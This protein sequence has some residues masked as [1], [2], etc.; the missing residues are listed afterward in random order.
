MR[1]VEIWTV[2][3]THTNL[4]SFS[5]K[6]FA[7][8]CWVGYKSLSKTWTCDLCLCFRD[9]NP[10]ALEQDCGTGCLHQEHQGGWRGSEVTSCS[11]TCQSGLSPSPTNTVTLWLGL[12]EFCI[13]WWFILTCVQGECSLTIEGTMLT[14]D[15]FPVLLW[16]KNLSMC[17]DPRG[18]TRDYFFSLCHEKRYSSLGTEASFPWLCL[19]DF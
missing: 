17:V 6:G 18:H 2:L 7:Q 11:Y 8:P 19:T 4:L 13:S 5:L 3:A 15:F 1:Y 12:T 14:Q 10:R 16:C 9:I